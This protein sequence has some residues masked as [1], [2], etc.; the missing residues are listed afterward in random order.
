MSEAVLRFHVL[1]L[2]SRMFVGPLSESI[3]Q[4]GQDKGLVEIHMYDIRKYAHDRHHTTDDYPFGGGPGMVMK[5]EPIFEA[6]EDAIK[7]IYKEGD[8]KGDSP[9]VV[10]L[11]PQGRPFTQ[12]IAEELSNK[13]DIILICGH[14][15]GVDQRVLEHLCTDEISIGDYVLTGG[16]LPA[17]VLIDA[18]SR[19]IPG[20]LGSIEAA[21]DDSFTTGLLQ[22]PQYTRPEHYKDMEVPPVLLSGNHAEIARWRREQALKKTA[23][24]RRDLLEGVTLSKEDEGIL[25]GLQ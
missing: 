25:K 4:R 23:E 22:F 2:F 16:E 18:V 6:V 11:S 9:P 15:E 12:A 17:M 19:L 1:T 3:I 8:R 21:W 7:A 20:V 5:P 14:Y 10:L 13:K 24:R